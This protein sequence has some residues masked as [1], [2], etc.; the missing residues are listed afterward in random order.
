MDTHTHTHTHRPLET[1]RQT[2]TWYGLG[3]VHHGDQLSLPQLVEAGEQ[4]AGAVGQQGVVAR[5]DHRGLDG[6]QLAEQG[7]AGVQAVGGALGAGRGWEET[8]SGAT[9]VTFS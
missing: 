8:R 4:G 5:V 9:G 2:G 1:D 6:L 3:P 7:Q